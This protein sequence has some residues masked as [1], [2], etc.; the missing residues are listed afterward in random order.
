MSTEKAPQAQARISLTVEVTLG[1]PWGDDE[2]IGNV[3][4][5]AAR[6]AVERVTIA[7]QSHPEIRILS[8]PVVT[9]VLSRPGGRP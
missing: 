6:D 8:E 9:A 4:K 7:I 5:Q 3:W 1:Q 2:T